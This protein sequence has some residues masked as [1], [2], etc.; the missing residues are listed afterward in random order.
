MKLRKYRPEDCE[1]I[2]SLFYHTVHTVNAKDYNEKQLKVWAT[3]TVDLSEWNETF[4]EH[5]TLIAEIENDIVGFGDMA[6]GGYLDR[7]YVHHNYLRRGIG[8][9][10]VTELEQQAE[11]MG[12]AVF[13][14][15]ASITAK[16]FFERLGY[17]SIRENKVVRGGVELLNYFMEKKV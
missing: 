2:A 14:T 1:A 11:A 7:L 16:P 4:M 15:Y 17:V 6:D 8:E 9:A 3:G 13:S 5:N 10:I 12:A